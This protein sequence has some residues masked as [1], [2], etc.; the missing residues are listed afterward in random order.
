MPRD[1][2]SSREKLDRFSPIFWE[3]VT[4][5]VRDYY[6]H[7]ELVAHVHRTCTKRDITRD[8]IVDRLRSALLSDPDVRFRDENQ[9]TYLDLLGEFQCL[10]KKADEDGKVEFART[11]AAIDFQ[12][13]EIQ[14]HFPDIPEQTN[15]CLSYA[16]NLDDPLNP[17]VFV[18]CPGENGPIWVYEI[19]P[20]A[21]EIAVPEIT[22]ATAPD[23]GTG[24]DLV[25]IPSEKKAG[26]D[27]PDAV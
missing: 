14:I 2:D 4:E 17:S 21:A 18:I 15:I 22:P 1:R 11:Q 6:R 7:Y 13:H 26:T 8:H 25:K 3:A 19:E 12:R 10:A 16:P 24:G 27:D 9:T 20:P 5:G 23:D